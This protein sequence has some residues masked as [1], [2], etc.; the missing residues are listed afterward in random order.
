[1]A[2]DVRANRRVQTL[3]NAVH[4]LLSEEDEQVSS[5]RSFALRGLRQP[6]FTEQCAVGRDI[7]GKNRRVDFMLYH[8]HRW[9]DCLGRVHA[10]EMK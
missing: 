8:P 6:I 4:D 9:P 7:Y 2:R 1:M 5:A 3:E 10:S